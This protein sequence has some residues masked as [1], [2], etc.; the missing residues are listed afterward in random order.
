MLHFC[1]LDTGGRCCRVKERW[2]SVVWPTCWH[3]CTIIVLVRSPTI[4][5]LKEISHTIISGLLL[6]PWDKKKE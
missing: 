1:L 4:M 2:R 6:T 3:T 5:F